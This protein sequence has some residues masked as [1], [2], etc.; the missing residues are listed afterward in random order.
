MLY[1]RPHI[2]DTV[3]QA[4]RATGLPVNAVARGAGVAPPV[5]H[6]FMNGQR[7]LTVRTLEKLARHLGL[8]LQPEP[9]RE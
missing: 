7:D 4:V 1:D 2:A 5:L 9:R 8:T 3:R 6:R